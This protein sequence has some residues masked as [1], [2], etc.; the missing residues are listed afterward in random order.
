M[1]GEAG[2]RLEQGGVGAR[3]P[4]SVT[5]ADALVNSTGEPNESAP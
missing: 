4:G 2:R 3:K 5:E 1:V